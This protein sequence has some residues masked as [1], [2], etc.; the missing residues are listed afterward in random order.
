MRRFPGPFLAVFFVG[1]RVQ[2]ADRNLRRGSNRQGRNAKTGGGAQEGHR[3]RKTDRGPSPS[4]RFLGALD[5]ALEVLRKGKGKGVFPVP[6]SLHGR[7]PH[8]YRDAGF[9][10]LG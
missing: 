7:S 3:S 2:I 9:Q 5:E 1:R 6:R 4:R 10:G 8:A